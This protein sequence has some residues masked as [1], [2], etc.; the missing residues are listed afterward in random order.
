MNNNS[1][2]NEWVARYVQQVGRQLP[3]AERAEIEK[4]LHSQIADQLD[5]RFG[6]GPSEAQ[7]HTVLREMGDPRKLAQNY[8]SKQ[9]LVGPDL[10]PSMMRLLHTGWGIVP[11]LTVIFSVFEAVAGSSGKSM[12]SMGIQAAAQALQ[13]TL[14]FTAITVLIFAVLQ[15]SGATLGKPAAFDPAA[16][17]PLEVG[18]GLDRIE[19]I[20]ESAFGAITAFATLYFLWVGGLTTRFD[21]VNPGS[22][23]AAPAQWLLG[24]LLC[25]IGMV[26]VNLWVLRRCYWTLLTRLLMIVL[27]IAD[28]LFFYL[29]ILRPLLDHVHRTYPELAS[30]VLFIDYIPLMIALVIMLTLVVTHGRHVLRALHVQRAKEFG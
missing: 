9:Y 15:H 4:E 22:V 25:N 20:M 17:P 26:G 21:L 24:F 8:G 6:S 18:R 29:A 14:T 13:A 11:T 7:V 30:K 2:V 12:I 3:E 16:L 23:I 10:Y 28:M 27:E 19:M 5:D 1:K